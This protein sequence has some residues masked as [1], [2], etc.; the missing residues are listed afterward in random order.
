MSVLMESHA[1]LDI[2]VAWYEA[3]RPAGSF[4]PDPS[5][6]RAGFQVIDAGKKMTRIVVLDRTEG[7]VQTDI[8]LINRTSK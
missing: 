1:P 4:L 3:Q 5:Q 2:V 7:H 8:V 6:D